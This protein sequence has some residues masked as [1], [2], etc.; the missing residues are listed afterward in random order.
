MRF[1]PWYPLDEAAAHAPAARG[2]FQVR[3]ADGLC[4]YPTGKSAMIHYEAADDVRAAAAAF[5]AGHPDRALLCRHT[6]E[7]EGDD[8]AAFHARLLRDFRARFGVGPELP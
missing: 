7:I 5:A 8:L 1:C 6:I 3:V 2:V 4:D